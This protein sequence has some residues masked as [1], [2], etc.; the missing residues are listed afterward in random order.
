MTTTPESRIAGRVPELSA[1]EAAECVPTDGTVLTSGF[2]RVG[3]PKAVPTA[4]AESDRSYGLTVVSGGS[5]GEEIDTALVESNSVD[6][7]F[8]YQATAAA[9]AAANDNRIAFHDRHI[10]GL[11]DEVQFRHLADPDV[12]LIEAVAVGEDWLIPSTSIGQTPAY[13]EA[14]EELIVELNRAQPRSLAAFHDV[15]RPAPPP[16]RG[17][18]PLTAPCE[19]IGDPRIRFGSETLLGV[20][21][22]EQPDSPYEFRDPTGTDEAIAANLGAFLEE[23]IERNP[24]LASAVR[25]QFGVGSLGNALAGALS[26][27]SFG[28]RT[29]TYYGEVFQDGLLDLVE[30]GDIAGASAT[31]LALSRDGQDRLFEDVER[32]AEDV[33]LRPADISNRAELVSRFGVVSIN[34]ALEVDVYG[35]ANST[36]VGGSRLLNGVGGSGDFVRNGLVSIVAL[37]ATAVE[38]SVSTIVPSVPHVD[39]TEHDIDVVITDHG[40][41]D[42]RGRSPMER[43]NAI[44]GSCA[45]PKTREALEAYLESAGSSGGHIHHDPEAAAGWEWR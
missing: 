41:A 35:H 28:D 23:E 30:D 45:A 14:A 2:G 7:R 43:A 24:A 32:Y 5:V 11:A 20:V 8:P 13:V 25:V 16:R 44:I 6:R 17:P 33:V 10:A 42:L 3:Y 9:R 37:P 39:H 18:V 40:V 22:T 12:A 26:D 4:I 34:S 27:V 29:V 21:E 19:R 31:S 1:T 36:H 15:Y 38:G